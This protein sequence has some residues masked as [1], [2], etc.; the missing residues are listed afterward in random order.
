MILKSLE[1][2]GFKSFPDKI[3]IRFDEGITA[4]V[5]PNGSGKSNISDAVRWVMGEQS[6][7][8]LRGSKMEDVIFDGTK[9]RK[10]MGFAEVTLTVDNSDRH[11]DFDSDEIA[12]TRRYYRSGDS[13]YRINGASV[14]LRDI[15]ELLMDT[16]LGRDGYSIVSQG[17]ITA[18]VE[19]RSGER[20]EMFE[21]AAG[22]SKFRY[23]KLEA[24][25]KLEQAEENLV[26][27]RDI[28]SELE[29]RVGPLRDQA[30]KA[31]K[32][33]EYANEKKGIEIGLWLANLEKI[34]EQLRD[35]ENKLAL[36]RLHQ[37]E[38]DNEIEGIV[39]E[40]DRIFNQSNALAV[41]IEEMTKQCGEFEE[42][43]IR[44]GAD[45]A[46]IE[47]DISFNL[48][49]IT[50][51]ESDLELSRQGADALLEEIERRNEQI[52]L[53]GEKERTENEEITRVLTE[54][55]SIRSN[56]HEQ[57]A[58]I[59]GLSRRLNELSIELSEKRV[60]NVSAVT[61]LDE[62]K[63]HILGFDAELAKLSESEAS[64]CAEIKDSKR[65]LEEVNERIESLSN[66]VSGYT[67]ITE[68]REKKR[69]QLKEQ[70]DALLL[71]IGEK[72]RRVK[73][74]EDM[75]KNLE[76][77][78]YS[79]KA[80]MNESKAGR[81]RGIKGP[82][83]RLI[84]V[85]SAHSLAIET[86]L[87]AAANNIVVENEDDAKQA[88]KF[89][90]KSD[91][92]R[93]T[94]LPIS[95]I[96]GRSLSEKGIDVCDGF[97]G[98]AAEL[99]SFKQE[100]REVVYNFLGK[101]V[102]VETID[103][104]VAMA[105]QFRYGFKIVTLDGQVVNA[106]GSITGGS[107]NKNAG[108]LSRRAKIDQLRDQ[109]LKAQAENDEIK[110]RLKTAISDA[111]A[112][113]AEL[114]GAKGELVSASEDKI[115]FEGELKM[116]GSQLD[117]VKANR[118]RLVQEQ[119]SSNERI[120]DLEATANST[121]KSCD[122][123][124][125]QMKACESE[126]EQLTGGRDAISQKREAL[127]T[128]LQTHKLE[129]VNIENQITVQ[130]N[131]VEDIK[132]RQV[133]FTDKQ[134]SMQEEKEQLLD[135]NRELAEEIER[136]NERAQQLREQAAQVKENAEGIRAQRTALEQRTVALR[137]SEREKNN[138]RDLIGRDMARLEERKAAQQKQYDD[139]ISRLWEEYELTR[140]E[141]ETAASPI[142]SI[143]S[144]SRRVSELK[145][146]IK[147]LGNVNVDAIE[148]YAEVSERYEFM[149]EQVDD[150]E[151]SKSELTKMISDFTS[152]MKEIFTERFAMINKCFGETFKELFGGGDAH[153]ELTEPEEVLTSGIAIFAQPPG[154]SI[155]RLESLS[156]GEKSLIAIAIYFAIM[157][158]NPAP[159][160]VLDE[161]EAALDDVN[162]DRF[163]EYLR[164]VCASTQ[165][166]VITHRRGTMEQ[167]DVIYGVTMQNSGVS[168]LLELNISQ[169]EEKLGI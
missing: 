93:A 163:A 100:Y 116:L 57:S 109:L 105:R 23:R 5:G 84:E 13:E 94:F 77:F 43:A 51:I 118:D 50:R 117:A 112:A 140:S 158:V 31:K 113:M 165:Y 141:A 44:A 11:I 34:T 21:E 168:K 62:I 146:K 157:K 16:G 147:A 83:I 58:A 164:K 45:A 27:L 48:Q 59:E 159:F 137:A 130:K 26:R 74:L 68:K 86:A 8:N 153:L 78:A 4:V 55:D 97:I 149:R 136:C 18:I 66:T 167:A 96:K 39:A 29:S 46:L 89:L 119:R 156:G 49:N 72:Q 67:L 155:G 108:V 38:A 106:G 144:A 28:L 142:E 53:L 148:E 101:V 138:E 95:T 123:L 63:A 65:V 42:D 15:H 40:I 124:L 14:R 151:R 107:S 70:S 135:K 85:D 143:T 47:K 120:A 71:D 161:I 103:D 37:E 81:L 60:Q 160:C 125:A 145:N 79:V 91:A 150:V 36:S 102:V 169:I 133:D 32:F 111:S 122:E 75:E 33:I 166:I 128:Q 87:G 110:E 20:R 76:G 41:R 88:V 9:E 82:L 30:E 19:S 152:Q 80:I 64:I 129:L 99:V 1:M 90:K 132:L 139:I 104:A 131:A 121:Q 17:K 56:E 98:F 2:M 115:R 35:F 73:L 69:D 12:I 52:V 10:A 126:M 24:E 127:S 25:K 22:I 134:S 154:K 3:V 92:G 7:K 61:Q 114:S 6:T 162:V 54:L